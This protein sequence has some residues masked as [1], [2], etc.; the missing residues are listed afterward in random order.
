MHLT[1]D[2]KSTHEAREIARVW[3][4]R[5]DQNEDRC[6]AIAESWFDAGKDQDACARRDL[7]AYLARRL[8]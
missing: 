8:Q 6:E 3:A 2:V 7:E 1:K 5:H 4:Y